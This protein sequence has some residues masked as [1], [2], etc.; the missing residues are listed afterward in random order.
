M[1]GLKVSKEHLMCG[2]LLT[3]TETKSS[4]PVTFRL[5]RYPCGKMVLQGG[6]SIQKGINKSYIDWEDMPVI[7]IDEC[8]N[9][10]PQNQPDE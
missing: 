1:N 8:G 6:F 7:D 4:T 5:A 2:F 9:E 3:D 10:K